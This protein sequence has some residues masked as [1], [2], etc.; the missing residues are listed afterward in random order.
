M[1]LVKRFYRPG[2]EVNINKLYKLLTGIDRSIDEYRWEWIDTWKGPG[3]MWLAFD[4]DREADDHLIMQYSLI[5]TPFSFW[6][7][8]YLAAKTE[9][10]MC[11]PDFRGKSQYFQHEKESFET[12]QKEY[13]L[14]FTTAGDVTKGTVGAIRRK[15]GYVAFDAWTQYVFCLGSKYLKNLITSKL[16]KIKK[17]PSILTKGIAAAISYIFSIYFRHH[18]PQRPSADIR[19]FNKHEAPLGEIESF[20]NLNKPF[21]MITVDRKSPYL[22][23]RINQNPYRDYTY[24]LL[25]KE[26]RLVGYAIFL[27]N[28]DNVVVITD[29]LAENKDISIFKTIVTYLI[30]HAKDLGAAAVTCSTLVNNAIL[31]DVFSKL[32]FINLYK[33]MNLVKNKENLNAFHVYVSSEID[34]KQ[35]PWDPRNWYVTDLVKEGR[36]R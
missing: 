30:R 25:Y 35:N 27:L 23:W 36:T 31:N 18:L 34:S 5:P 28:E 17:T 19:I 16:Q 12:A 14:F 1:K 9:N 15:L 2:D 4:E 20:W 10:C 24:L 21:Y 22:S 33:L 29:I 6:G 7:K 3:R 26:N 13:G 32:K 8:P 11:H